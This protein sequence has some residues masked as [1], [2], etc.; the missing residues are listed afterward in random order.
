MTK[1]QQARL[2]AWRLKI[3]NWAEGEPRQVARTCRYFGI[4]GE[5]HDVAFY[6]KHASGSALTT[7]SP[8]AVWQ[9]LCRIGGDTRYFAFEDHRH[10]LLA[11]TGRVGAAVLV[12]AGAG[13]PGGV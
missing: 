6:A 3:L 12:C 8:E 7:A 5:R 10:G 11:S 4:R 1:A 2:V 13:T 9:V